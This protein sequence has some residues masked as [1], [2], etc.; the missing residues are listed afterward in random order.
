MKLYIKP[1]DD[2]IKNLYENHS[3]YNPGDSG[4]DLFCPDRVIIPAKT[5]KIV[6]LKIKCEAFSIDYDK[7][8]LK[9]NKYI[10]E[11]TT[12]EELKE[13]VNNIKLTEQNCSFY[14]LA[15]S[16]ISNTPLIF[17]NSVG[18]M[19]A[20]Y[21]GHVKAA[22]YNLSDEDYIITPLQRLVQICS[23]DLKQI[24][25][26]VVNTLSDT[27]RGEGGFGSTN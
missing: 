16:S 3:T 17:K 1:D 25:F 10:S 8:F 6:N 18:V 22:F 13:T 19:D 4:L 14:L 11:S 9:V 5:T 24:K 12:L 2:V 15:R 21:R 20:G 26:E 27:Q 7:E 23:P